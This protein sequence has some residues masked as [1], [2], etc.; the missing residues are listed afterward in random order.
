MARFTW[1]LV[2]YRLQMFWKLDVLDESENVFTWFIQYCITF[3]D[4]IEVRSQLKAI[5]FNLQLLDL[6][7]A[8]YI[9]H[10]ANKAF[11]WLHDCSNVPTHMARRPYLLSGSGQGP[12]VTLLPTND[13]C[14]A[15]WG[16]DPAV[17]VWHSALV[18]CPWRCFIDGDSFDKY[19]SRHLGACHMNEG[20]EGGWR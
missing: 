9:D 18:T 12:E 2:R 17:R 8:W 5:F 16:V 4:K 11:M 15:G 6:Q 10:I 13:S 20:A 1:L 3:N 14:W 7:D 19:Q